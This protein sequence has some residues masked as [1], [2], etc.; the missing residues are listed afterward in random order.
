MPAGITRAQILTGSGALNESEGQEFMRLVLFDD[1]GQPFNLVGGQT[2]PQGL[3]GLRGADGPQGLKGD[4][5]DKGD[6]GDVGP[7]G[8]KGDRGDVGLQGLKGDKGDLGPKGDVGEPGPPGLK[9]DKGDTGFTG[10][11]GLTGPKGD[12][13][14]IG[15]QGLKG[16]KGDQGVQGVPG[17]GFIVPVV[18]VLPSNPV[19]GDWCIFRTSQPPYT[20]WLLRYFT[21][22]HALDGHGWVFLGGSDIFSGPIDLGS[23]GNKQTTSTAYV[24]TGGV[25]NSFTIPVPGIYDITAQALVIGP[26]SLNGCLYS[27]AIG[28]VA[29]SD[30]WACSFTIGSSGA[31]L[32][33]TYR[34]TITVGNVAVSDRF[35]ITGGAAAG[36][37]NTR[38]LSA[39]PVRL[40]S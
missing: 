16:D 38:S 30:A 1:E 23:A 17:I 21:A 4:K 25:S 35:R 3:Q 34:H 29:A 13:G 5:G 15:P 31:S 40:K 37:V 27:Y 19:D 12:T 11:V 33:R 28:A 14:F 10:G 36:I 9:G 2:G 8:V 18:T 39:R 7:S 20:D 6:R 22:Y 32:M 24:L 26:G